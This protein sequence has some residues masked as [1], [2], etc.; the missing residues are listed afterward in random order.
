MRAVI[1]ATLVVVAYGCG[2]CMKHCMRERGSLKKRLEFLFIL[3]A[4]VT[5]PQWEAR[6]I[7]VSEHSEKVLFNVSLNLHTCMQVDPSRGFDVYRHIHYDATNQR[8]ARYED[9]RMT[10]EHEQYYVIDLF[11]PTVS[12]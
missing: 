11:R 6:E 4:A 7:A 1:L 2:E 3:V 5:P 12:N 8:I 9:L 10:N